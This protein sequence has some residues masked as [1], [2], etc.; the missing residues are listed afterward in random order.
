M[1]LHRELLEKLLEWK[2]K[3]NRK[4]LI[5][6]GARQ[7][8]KTWIL[9]EF[10]KTQFKDYAIFNFD[11]REELKEFFKS[12]K[13]VKRIIDNLSLVHGKAIIPNET[14]IIFDEI[15]ESNNALNALKYFYE[16]APEYYVACAGSLL[17][18]A[19]NRGASFPVGKVDFLNIYPMTFME[20]LYS[21][22]ISLYNYLN[23]I[24]KI[25]AIP[26]IFFNQL[27]DKFK[28]YYISGGMPEAVEELLETGDIANVQ[29]ILR[30]ILNSYALDFS[31]HADNSDVIKIGYVWNSLPSQ[32]SRENKKFLYKVIKEGAR[33]REYEN[34][35]EW[36][37]NAGLIYKVNLC[38]K[39]SLPLSAYDELSS[40]KIYSMDLGLLREQ[41]KLSPSAIAEGNRLLTEFKG[42]LTENYI[43]NTLINLYDNNIRYWTS[44]SKAEVDFIVQR[45][46][47][48]IPIEVKADEN[49]TG[50]SLA[51]Y[52]KTY[53][54][55]LSIRY[56]LKNL[57]YDNGLLNIPLFMADMTEFLIAL[58]PKGNTK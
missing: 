12:T 32:L 56:S 41:Y 29:N 49:V 2:D 1:N 7:V 19:M 31:K 11:E 25:E 8:G 46:N 6:H 21:V 4:P 13:D 26:E 39:P 5:L 3:R 42:A 14:L 47:E 51:F 37:S 17:G 57:K 28:M 20:F 36:L 45:D 54:P 35:L 30:N 16:N 22:D 9:K 44:S 33:A 38:T 40:F 34:S 43:L 48:I 52:R 18:V 24:T 55:E 58:L 10:G 53:N 50:K 27:M 15:Q 23:G